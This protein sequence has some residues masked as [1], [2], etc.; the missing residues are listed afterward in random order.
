MPDALAVRAVFSTDAGLRDVER[1]YVEERDLD[2]IHADCVRRLQQD[3]CFVVKLCRMFTRTVPLVNEQP[4]WPLAGP[5]T[6][7]PEGRFR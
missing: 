1:V 5:V 4:L 6:R 2:V 3:G 7:V